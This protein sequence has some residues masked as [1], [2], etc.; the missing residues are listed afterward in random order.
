MHSVCPRQL[1]VESSV[2]TKS[3]SVFVRRQRE[4]CFGALTGAHLRCHRHDRID[5]IDEARSV[6]FGDREPDIASQE[7]RF[8]CVEQPDQSKMM[9]AERALDRIGNDSGIG[10]SG[11]TRRQDGTG[12]GEGGDT[13]DLRAE[14]LRRPE[15]KKSRRQLM[16]HRAAGRHRHARADDFAGRAA[17]IQID[18]KLARELLVHLQALFF[19]PRTVENAKRAVKPPV[20]QYLDRK[21]VVIGGFAA[22][23]IWQLQEIDDQSPLDFGGYRRAEEELPRLQPFGRSLSS[24]K[25]KQAGR[26]VQRDLRSSE[27]SIQWRL[28]EI[29]AERITMGLQRP[30][31]GKSLLD[32]SRYSGAA[33]A[34]INANGVFD[35]GAGER[36]VENGKFR[37]RRTVH[38][39]SMALIATSAKTRQIRNLRSQ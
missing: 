19:A 8:Q 39:C 14:R 1:R 15:R 23:R 21:R 11:S 18:G 26:T 35:D 37:F 13:A 31:K 17:C 16:Q 7:R 10:S 36:A 25:R 29:M 30:G 38:G 12:N 2:D 24:G 4:F 3:V 20:P 22:A 32:K 28:T 6:F 33:L 9:D 34:E 27:R 5:Q